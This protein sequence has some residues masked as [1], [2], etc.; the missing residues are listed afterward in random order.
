MSERGEVG[1]RVSLR[2]SWWQHREG[3]NPFAPTKGLLTWWNWYTRG[4]QKAVRKHRG[5]MPL[6]STRSSHSFVQCGRLG[7]LEYPLALGA[8]LSGFEAPVG[9]QKFNHI[10]GKKRNCRR[11]N[12]RKVCP[13]CDSQL[14][15]FCGR[16]TGKV[17]AHLAESQT[18]SI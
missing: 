5:S 13:N 8:R 15:T 14:L 7:E 6:V 2:C 12:F 17:R 3:S 16:N 9:H 1:R 18:R 4:S 11:E 10:N